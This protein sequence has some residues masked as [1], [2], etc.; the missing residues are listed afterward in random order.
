VA[1]LRAAPAT[2]PPD[3]AQRYLALPDTIPQRVR[4][5]TEQVVKGAETRYDQAKAIEGYLRT[6]T[7]TL[8]LPTPPADRDI[9]D[10]FLFDLKK[11]YCDYYAS[12]M[13]VMAR[14]AGVPARFASGYAQGTYDHQAGHWVIT[15]LNAHSWVEIYFEG[16]GWVEFEPTA[17]LPPLERPSG[18]EATS[19]TGSQPT[20]GLWGGRIPWALIILAGVL[21]LLA[22]IVLLLWRPRRL[23]TV[24]A[25]DLIRDRYTRL[26]R[27]GR[28]LGQP[29]QDSQT[30][31]EYG[32][33][34]DA[35][36]AARGQGSRWLRARNA[37]I[38]APAEVDRLTDTFV[39]AQYGAEQI[40]E[41]EGWH[42]RDLWLRLRRYLWWLWFG[43][44]S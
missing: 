4:D 5:L 40:G 6:Y 28:R 20:P 27:W 41:R 11:G 33:T 3:L 7:Y 18:G 17:G 10:Y 12:A 29:L 43:H 24:R 31:Y 9:V 37:G 23:Q 42:I 2:L 8:D 36:L 13:V 19:P 34:L 16:I 1:D 15:E 25:A 22:A 30:P 21:A 26:L 35:T 38:Q 39:Q 14:S 32:A 44:L